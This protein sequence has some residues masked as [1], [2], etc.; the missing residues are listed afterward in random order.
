MPPS[1]ARYLA[2]LVLSPGLVKDR[3][4]DYVALGHI[5]KAQD[6]NEATRETHTSSAQSG[7]PVV[8]PGSIERVDFGE[9]RDDKFFVLVELDK[10]STSYQWRQL[11]NIRKFFDCRKALTSPDEVMK[12]LRAELPTKTEMKDAVVRLT[13]D[14]PREY[15]PFIDEGEL[16]E[17]A[18]ET[19]EFHLVKRPQIEARLRIPDSENVGDL[20]AFQL[21]DIYWDSAR[22]EKGDQKSLNKL[23]KE[24]IEEI[25]S[26]E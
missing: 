5:H 11:Q 14:Y 3:R 18:S 10:D 15:E 26:E 20:S 24:I 19:F 1:K 12:T 2:E 9:V 6:V 21:L 13:I 7:P 23:A 22:I 4:L 16:R 25:P 17:A 8:Y